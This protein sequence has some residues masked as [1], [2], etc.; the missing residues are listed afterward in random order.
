M[1]LRTL[2]FALIVATIAAFGFFNQASAHPHGGGGH[3]GHGGHWGGHGWHGG[4]WGGDYDDGD[5]Y[6]TRWHG[7]RVWVCD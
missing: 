3:W 1:I 7:R 2:L 5:C 6:W 4:G